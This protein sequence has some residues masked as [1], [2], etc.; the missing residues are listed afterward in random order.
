MIQHRSV[1]R[2]GSPTNWPRYGEVLISPIKSG[3]RRTAGVLHK[4]RKKSEKVTTNSFQHGEDDGG[5]GVSIPGI[6]DE[7]FIRELAEVVRGRT[8]LESEAYVLAPV[9]PAL[10][11][12]I[13]RL[14]SALSAM[15]EKWLEESAE[16]SG[17]R[18]RLEEMA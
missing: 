10:L 7:E 16:C 4:K 14:A 12:E 6:E 13:D 11:N 8:P 1:Q 15:E 3:F 9:V 18:A 2:N 5:D 17:L